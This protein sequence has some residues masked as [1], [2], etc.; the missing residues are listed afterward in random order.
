MTIEEILDETYITKK[1]VWS[2]RG[3]K[4]ERREVIISEKYKEP[5]Q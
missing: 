1:L 4:I 5:K 3:D 2:K